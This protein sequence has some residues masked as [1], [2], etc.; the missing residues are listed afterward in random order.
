MINL[1]SHASHHLL[2]AHIWLVYPLGHVYVEPKT[3]IQT[4]QGQWVFGG[5]QASSV[6]IL[7]LILDQ[8]KAPVHLINALIF[9]FE[10]LLYVLLD[11][12]L[13]PEIG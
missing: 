12:A 5:P 13:S 7:I 3:K 10:A 9:Y 1:A 6:R 2:L 11:C 8:G 4:E